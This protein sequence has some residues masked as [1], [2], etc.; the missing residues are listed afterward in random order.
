MY[1]VITRILLVRVMSRKKALRTI[2]AVTRALVRLA[3]E[4][5]ARGKRYLVDDT[6]TAKEGGDSGGGGDRS[7]TSREAEEGATDDVGPFRFRRFDVAQCP[8]DHH[9]LDSMEQVII[10]VIID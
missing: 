5:F 4:A 1:K 2:R 8:M 10:R 7:N 9:F 3:S 6:A